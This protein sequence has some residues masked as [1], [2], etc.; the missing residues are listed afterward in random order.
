MFYLFDQIFFEFFLKLFDFVS[1]FAK[2]E[3]NL[4]IFF[5]F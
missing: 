4:K 3:K 1:K 2:L 5:F